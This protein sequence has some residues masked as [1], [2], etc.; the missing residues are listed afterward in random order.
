MRGRLVVSDSCQG[1]LALLTLPDLEICCQRSVPF[2]PGKLVCGAAL[3]CADVSEPAVY[4]IHKSTL[5]AEAVFSAGPEIEAL[6]LSEDGARLYALAG[7]ADS[8]QMLETRRGQLHGALRIG[9]HPRSLAGAP[10]GRRLAV[11]CGGTCDVALLEPGPLRVLRAFPVGGVACGACFFA[12]QWM[13]LCAAGEYDMGTVVGA[14]RKGGTWMPWVRL[15]GLPG[16]MASCGGGLLVGHMN[17]LTMLDAP[18]G[19]IRWQTTIS[20]LPTAIVPVG[21]AACF[22]DSLDGLIGLVDLR[23]GTVLRRLLVKE[24]AGLAVMEG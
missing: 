23:R 2:R 13:A 19:R 22:A 15:P 16:A 1:L 8:V 7:G 17:R 10:D 14:I 20:G 4:R 21:R 5:E 24:P 9:L 11:A 3:Y 18:N 12:G 6:T